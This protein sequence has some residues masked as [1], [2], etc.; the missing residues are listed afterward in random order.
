MLGLLTASCAGP[1]P[2]GSSPAL[3]KRPA[4]DTDMPVPPADAQYTIYCHNYQGPNH[5]E[6]ARLVALQLRRGTSLKDWYVVHKTDSSTLYYGFYR[7]DNPRDPND[8]KEGQRAIQDLDSI[9][10]MAD[11]TGYRPFSESLPVLLDSP[12]PTA[13]PKW[14]LTHSGGYY[15]LEIAV[16]KD[17]PKRKQYA[18]D[19]VRAARAAGI[20]A[21][22]YHG[23]TSS[24]VCIGAWPQS[25][26]QEINPSQEN[27]DPNVP[28]VLT[29]SPLGE[30][31]EKQFAQRGIKAVAPRLDPI[32]PDMIQ[33]MR[34]FPT[35]S[36]NGEY[37][38]QSMVDPAT[39]QKKLEPPHSF[40]VKVPAADSID[41]QSDTPM[42]NNN[43]SPVD[44]R[45]PATPD[46][47][48]TPSGVGQLKSLGD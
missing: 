37:L 47:P 18:V 45:P 13:D 11:S 29:P 46:H 14:D 30:D 28:L 22:Y 38:M 10:S 19:A 33:A 42:V 5:V 15:S 26:A 8:A 39:G 24:S 44:V 20:E 2:V 32:D 40:L 25:S 31:A 35:H 4:D 16:Y 21:Y 48:A 27:T 7:T 17:S 36:V 6:D 23:P 3:A 1:A 41:E 9:R 12:D 43:A 34:R